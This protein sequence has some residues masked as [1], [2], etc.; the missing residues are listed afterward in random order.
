[1]EFAGLAESFRCSRR[2]L[3]APEIFVR[4]PKT[5][6]TA[7]FGSNRAGREENPRPS[8]A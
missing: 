4:K 2:N 5:G 3:Q 1:M 7:L 8:G 6:L